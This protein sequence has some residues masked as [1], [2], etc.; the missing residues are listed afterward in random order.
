ML[1][2]L[3]KK[4]VIVCAAIVMMTANA[5]A[6]D[7]SGKSFDCEKN[8]MN[9]GRG[10]VNVATCWMELPRC[11]VYHNSQLPVLGLVVGTCQGAGFTVI[12][13]FAGVADLLSFGFMT[14]SI[15]TSCH[16]FDE[17]VWDERWVPHN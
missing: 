2:S 4:T 15:Y 6:S 10:L 16:G 12:R 1:K 13:A 3:W 8:V 17:W 9:M 11:M 5:V 14:D 7:N